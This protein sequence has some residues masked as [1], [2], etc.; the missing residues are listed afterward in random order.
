MVD[1][2][3]HLATGKVTVF[4]FHASWCPPCR[5]VDRHLEKVLRRRHDVAVRRL[6]VAH[7][8]SEVA[9][10]YLT[11]VPGLPFVV[12]FG[13]AGEPVAA[14]SG[15]DLAALDAAIELGRSPGPPR[16]ERAPR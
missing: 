6:N 9:R 5:T 4:D 16:N 15:L 1:L 10:A 12:V 14:I 2:R 13:V 11:N 7:W 8:E 3:A